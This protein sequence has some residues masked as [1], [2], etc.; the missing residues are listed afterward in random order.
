[1]P[2]Y[3]PFADYVRA[4]RG[5]YVGLG[6]GDGLGV[7]VETRTHKEIMRLT[8]GKGITDYLEPSLSRI[9][10]T[11][12]LPKGSTSDDDQ[13]NRCT[14]RSLVISRGFN[15]VAQGLGLVDEY[16]HSKFGW[17]G[18][19]TAAAIAIKEWRDSVGTKGRHPGQPAPKPTKEHPSAGSGPAMKVYALA[20]Y[21][22]IGR[23]TAHARMM[24]LDHAM[25]LALMTHG[26]VRA[27]MASVALGYAI[28]AFAR[29]PP[30]SAAP[31]TPQKTFAAKTAAEI[32][33]RTKHAENVYRFFRPE[34]TPPFSTYL[35]KAFALL[36]D[37]VKLRTEVNTGFLA[38]ESVP[39]AIATALRHPDNFRA[40]IC[41]GVNAGH[42]TDTVGAMIGGMVG[43]RV[44]LDGI[45]AEWRSGL[46]D[47]DDLV[48]EANQLC[49][50]AYGLDP[51]DAKRVLPP[52]LK[53]KTH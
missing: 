2:S 27:C 15:I 23:N 24:F 9:K 25:S 21:E 52:W 41:E 5:G 3:M 16:E 53:N 11:Q 37:S 14:G 48:E 38:V 13:L 20:A 31:V 46:L 42:D 29:L 4:V 39:F 19:T 32:L 22:L 30:R 8:A 40:A 33:V 50:T 36:D 10:D 51:N 1:M 12:G 35:E 49:L 17:G 47:H 7:P 28:G 26:D 34:Q 6:T 44:G 43:S 45:P 18:T